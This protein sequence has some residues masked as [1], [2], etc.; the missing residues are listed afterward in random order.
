MDFLRRTIAQIQS[1]LGKLTTSQRMVIIL[2][3]G[4]LFIGAF[5]AANYSSKQEMAPLLNQSLTT[6]EIAAISGKLDMW[7]VKY[8]LVGDRIHVASGNVR[9]VLYRLTADQS[10]PKD[11]H[12]GWDSL[13]EETNI[14]IPESVREDKRIITRQLVLADAIVNTWSGVRSAQ[15]IINP[16][17]KRTLNNIAPVASASVTVQMAQPE[18]AGRKMAMGI[19]D[20]I[21]SANNRMKRENVTVIIDGK[22]YPIQPVGEEIASEYL[23]EKARYEEHFRKKIIEAIGIANAIVQVDAKIR[24]SRLESRTKKIFNDGEGSWNPKKET[25]GREDSSENVAAKAEP[26]MMANIGETQASPGV[27]QSENSTEDSAVTSPFPGMDDKYE[28]TPAGGTEDITAS[29]RLPWSYFADI[30]KQESAAPD[31]EPASEAVKTVFARELP[32]IRAIVMHAIGLG[33]EDEEKVVVYYYLG[34]S[35]VAGSGLMIPGMSAPTQTGEGE[36]AAATAS[37]TLVGYLKSNTKEIAVTSLAMISLFMVLMMVRKAAGPVDITHEEAAAMMK[38]STIT[39][40]AYDAEESDYGDD[41]ASVGLLAG[42]ELSKDAVRSQKVLAQIR[43]MVKES[44]EM[45][46][47]LLGKWISQD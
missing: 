27:S 16:G 45:A 2:L 33:P 44:P 41:D 7:D 35:V 40:E 11:T 10:L 46:A 22:M 37:S 13:V 4:M 20:F 24:T 39:P 47:T 1:Q 32:T 6:A 5:W 34:S 12:I 29:V 17:S 36:N 8:K 15:V 23:E 31:Q 14:L 9:P 42:V 30:A 3:V 25:S 28:V 43:E 26:G 38:G 19:A 18:H 21:A